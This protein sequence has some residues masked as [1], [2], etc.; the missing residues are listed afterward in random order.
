M[1]LTYVSHSTK[2]TGGINMADLQNSIQ[3]YTS[4]LHIGEFQIAYKGIMETMTSIQSFSK[5]VYPDYPTSSLY[6]GYMDMT[7]FAITPPE[8]KREKLKIVIVYLHPSMRFEAWLCGTN[9]SIQ[10][11]FHDRFQSMDIK[12]YRLSPILPNVDSI[13]ETVL[14]QDPDFDDLQSMNEIL[15]QRLDVFIQ[16]MF[17]LVASTNP[18]Q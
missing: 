17:V 2:N 4:V 5:S 11:I 15:H 8:L 6:F 7:Y 14:L 10:R 1:Y 16:D 3:K 9:K 18:T 13:L 12:G